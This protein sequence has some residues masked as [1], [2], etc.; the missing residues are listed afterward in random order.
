[1]FSA[2]AASAPSA[3]T[4]TTSAGHGARC[5]S[6]AHRRQRSPGCREVV[7]ACLRTRFSILFP[8]SVSSAGSRVSE[9]T[10]VSS[11]VTATA[12]TV[13]WNAAMPSVNMPS[14][15]MITL[16]PANSTERPAVSS[17]VAV[18]C[19]RSAP[20]SSSLR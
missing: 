6:Q 3:I 12:V 13:P 7:A 17:A 9:A 1:M 20:R 15:A 5:T 8:K 4:E 2:G 11:T 10:I 19:A 18:A 14:S 16:A